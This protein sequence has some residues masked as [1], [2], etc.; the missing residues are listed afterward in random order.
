M[1]GKIQS[2]ELKYVRGAL[3]KTR[4]DWIRNAVLRK[5]LKIETII[6]TIERGQ[7]RWYRHLIH[8]SRDKPVKSRQRK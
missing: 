5:K 6:T 2:M 8:M 3:G 4:K 1:I 7:L